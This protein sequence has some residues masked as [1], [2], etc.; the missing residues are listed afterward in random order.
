[1][2]IH[3]INKAEYDRLD[4]QILF[5]NK[6]ADRCYAK[7]SNRNGNYF[8]FGWQ[9]DLLNP[10]IIEID[11]SIY[12]IGIDLD[13]IIINMSKHKII[14]HLILSNFFYDIKLFGNDICIATELEVII[15]DKAHYK[16]KDTIPLT[17][18]YSN[19]SFNDN[20]L[21]IDTI[22]NNSIKYEFR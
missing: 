8:K 10:Q 19:M 9:S 13:F 6:Q 11:Y 7:I 4:C 2:K 18:F 3:L 22:D 15:M 5:E 1:M 17:D 12:A 14:S 20:F 16:I 21:I